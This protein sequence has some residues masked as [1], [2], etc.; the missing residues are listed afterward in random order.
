MLLRSRVALIA[1]ASVVLAT[2]G[3]A[4]IAYQREA[5]LQ[6]FFIDRA[7]ATRTRLWDTVTEDALSD[8]V[9]PAKQ[10]QADHDLVSTLRDRELDAAA[11]AAARLERRV[12]GRVDLFEIY[13]RDGQMI[14]P[15]PWDQA[16]PRAKPSLD[17]ATL[18]T[19]MSGRRTLRGLAVSGPD[20]A[21]VLV[22]PLLHGRGVVGVVMLGVLVERIA[23]EMKRIVNNDFVLVTPDGDFI[24]G[25]DAALWA[26]LRPFWNSS[27][28][29]SPAAH[30]D[31]RYFVM[32]DV[33]Q[34]DLMGRPA[35]EQISIVDYTETHQ[36]RLLL[37]SLL[38][39]GIPL[40][41]LVTVGFLWFYL[42]RA[43]ASLDRPLEVLHRL[44]EGDTS[45]QVPP[46][47]R[48]DEIGQIFGAVESLRR[49]VL[50]LDELRRARREARLRQQGL[51]RQEMTGLA[52]IL[53]EEGRAAVIAE[54]ADLEA[55][56]AAPSPAG[57]APAAPEASGEEDGGGEEEGLDVMAAAFQTMAERVRHQQ[58]DLKRLVAELREAL[59]SQG[60]LA[61]LHQEL[62][63]ARRLQQSTLPQSLPDGA[64]CDIAGRMEPAQEVGGDFYDFFVLEGGRVGLAIADVSDKGVPAAFVTGITRVLLRAAARLALSPAECLHQLN[65]LLW[66]DNRVDVFVTMFYAV[67][68]GATGRL[69]Y[70]NAGHCPPRLVG[71]DGRV[72]RIEPTGGLA[73]A[74]LGDIA[75]REE[76][77]TLAPGETVVLYTD[78]VT[79]A[80]DPAGDQFGEPRMDAV[81]AAAA[82]APPDRLLAALMD[83]VGQFAAGA[84]R[85]DD[86]TCLA[87]R[88][89]GPPAA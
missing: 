60:E 25:T 85:A 88:Y 36:G 39:L 28:A 22:A 14:Y 9:V 7:T 54:L 61:A 72:R 29:D 27:S 3:V 37:N 42:R 23:E 4:A 13:A 81:L 50:S 83:R 80:L 49:S 20:G 35:A 11:V 76:S 84:P 17:P 12:G 21:A 52:G 40:L 59:K 5:L 32:I 63:I 44:A 69:V 33:A 56:A 1:L 73:L 19:V 65:E 86:I 41:I 24:G 15:A 77:L 8:L 87:L 74:V 71:A 75:Y 46:R 64:A 10:V 89:R 6:E 58:V 78:G 47:R 34:R 43:F 79:D 18:E 45:M 70:A 62:E 48:K 67:L 68:D 2:G 30:F 55:A 53:D 82:G 57:P 31:G 38:L 26:H 16:A 66:Q 51:I